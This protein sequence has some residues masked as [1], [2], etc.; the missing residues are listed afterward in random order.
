MHT[1]DYI[2]E[3]RAISDAL[4]DDLADWKTRIDD[5][6]TTASTGTEILMAL[7]WNLA[8]LLKANPTLP[9][10][11]IMRIKDYLLAANKLLG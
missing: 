11:L 5:A 7:R 2:A 9:P 4:N 8:E 1:F 6:I 10:D 3:A